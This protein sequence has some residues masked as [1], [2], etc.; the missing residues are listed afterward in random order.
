MLLETHVL[1]QDCLISWQHCPGISDQGLLRATDANGEDVDFPTAYAPG[2]SLLD[3]RW[4]NYWSRN[5]RDVRACT[6]IHNIISEQ[7]LIVRAMAIDL[8][9]IAFRASKTPR[10]SPLW[11]IMDALKKLERAAL[12]FEGQR[13]NPNRIEVAFVVG[14]KNRCPDFLSQN[15]SVKLTF[16]SR[17][18]RLEQK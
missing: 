7:M 6:T 13:F 4:Y 1:Q 14:Q 17:K 11:P 18:I 3:I 9:L 10:D 8:T 15:F 16:W 12:Q 5:L 2:W